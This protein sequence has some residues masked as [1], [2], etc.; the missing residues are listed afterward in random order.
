ML[1]SVDYV[2][3][4]GGMGFDDDEED[5]QDKMDTA[6]IQQTITGAVQA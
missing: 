6:E 2:D 5:P 4:D 3:D 1:P